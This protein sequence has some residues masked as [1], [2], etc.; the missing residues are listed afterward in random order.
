M[1]FTRIMIRTMQF[2]PWSLY[3]AVQTWFIHVFL[4]NATGLWCLMKLNKVTDNFT[5][6]PWAINSVKN[7]LMWDIPYLSSYHLMRNGSFSYPCNIF[8]LK[9][10]AFKETMTSSLYEAWY[11]PHSPVYEK[12][13]LNDMIVYAYKLQTCLIIY[14]IWNKQCVHRYLVFIIP[15]T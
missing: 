11:L 7:I 1:T 10:V 13:F 6:K 8:N 9:P 2:K 4:V 5:T 12:F 3:Y 15:I 14:I